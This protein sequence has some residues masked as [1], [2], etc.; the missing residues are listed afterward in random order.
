MREDDAGHRRLVAYV[1]PAAGAPAGP[2]AAGAPGR[3]RCPDYM[4]PA[5]FVVL[6]ALPL[7]PNGKVDRRALPAPGLA[8]A[9]EPATWRRGPSRARCWPASG[10]TCCGCRRVGVDDNFFE[11]GGDSILSIQVVS[12]ARRPACG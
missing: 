3:P 12:R 9:A 6:D 4:V 1:V 5:A 10:P 8:A 2:G 7:D 11:L